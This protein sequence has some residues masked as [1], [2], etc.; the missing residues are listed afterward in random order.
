MWSSVGDI[1]YINVFN[2]YI[3]NIVTLVANYARRNPELD[4]DTCKSHKL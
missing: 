1:L 2:I 4:I 3:S